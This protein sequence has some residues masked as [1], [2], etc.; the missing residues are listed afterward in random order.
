MSTIRILCD[1][2]AKEL[3]PHGMRLEGLIGRKLDGEIVL[4]EIDEPEH[5]WN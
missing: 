4:I 3:E 2:L 1:A 5:L